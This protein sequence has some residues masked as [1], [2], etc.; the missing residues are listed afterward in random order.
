MSRKSVLVVE[1]DQ[2]IL[3]LVRYNLMREGYA[4]TCVKTSEDAQRSLKTGSPSLILLDLMLPGMSGLEFCRQLVKNAET[5]AIPV[6]MMTAKTEEI[7]IV[8]GLEVGAVDYITKPFSPR[9]LLARVRAALRR[10]ESQD[11]D[12][13]KPVSIH[14]LSIHPGRREVNVGERRVELTHTEFG[15][16]YMLASRPGWVYSRS[17][18]TEEV[19]GDR[20]EVTDRAVDVHIAGLRK[21]LGKEGELV[22]TVRGVGYR[23][24]D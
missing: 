8:T 15:V 9:V 3:E 11:S 23:F 7:D 17:E 4:V 12:L 1:D 19:R 13:V 22:E 16:L 10:N 18:I 24:R 6:I 21:K 5:A 20:D 2:D 14:G